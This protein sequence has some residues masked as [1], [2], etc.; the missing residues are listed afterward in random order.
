MA[1]PTIVPAHEAARLT[2]ESTQAPI[3]GII[4]PNQLR[5][6]SEIFAPQALSRVLAEV[7]GRPVAGSLGGA[8][9]FSGNGPETFVSDGKSL[10]RQASKNG[11]REIHLVTSS[12]TSFEYFGR[13][14]I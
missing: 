5:T 14:A 10:S 1:N 11:R 8:S 6:D 12:C 9:E 7:S 2:C 3:F 13:S 4:S